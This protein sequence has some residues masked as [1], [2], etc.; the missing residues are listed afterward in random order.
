VGGFAVGV[1][2][3]GER[4]HGLRSC[5]KWLLI[6]IL[7]PT[8]GDGN[9]AVQCPGGVVGTTIQAAPV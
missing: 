3:G 1:G 9:V 5:W 7:R 4:A 2:D 8:G 6:A